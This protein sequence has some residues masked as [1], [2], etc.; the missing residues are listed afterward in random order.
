M[1]YKVLFSVIFILLVV[2]L[3]SY[4][5]SG[6]KMTAGLLLTFDDRN[7]LH[8][9]KQ[10]PLFKKYDAHV[11]FF[12]DHFDELTTD[13]ILALKRLKEAGHAIGCHGMRHRDAVKFSDEYSIEKY[14][15]DEI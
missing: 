15:Y 11:T 10:I 7:I 3:S 5:T 2:F 9:E 14:I 4:K 12:I 6:G 13:Q 8:W 1:R